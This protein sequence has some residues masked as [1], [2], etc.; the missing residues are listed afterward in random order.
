MFINDLKYFLEKIDHYRDE[1]L[2]VFIKPCWPRKISPNQL[3]YIRIAIGT[4]LIVLLFFFKIENKP[5]IISL[6]CV[7]AITDIFDGSVA[8]GLSEV[9][10]LGTMLDP[11]ADRILILPIAIYSLYGPHKW[12]LLFFLLAEALGAIISI[13][14]KSK[15]KDIKPNIFGKT[16][17][18]LLSIVFAGILIFWPE[19]PSIFFIDIIWISLFFLC[20]SILARVL[21]MNKKG[22]IKNKII[23]KQ[24][25]HYEN[26]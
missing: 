6:F 18:V 11:I 24:L 1:L 23:N 3:T 25:Q 22:F 13:F 15:D 17:M 16:K 7:G 10:E 20:L 5:L 21:E 9:S 19:P 14:H 4:V 26:L 8:R 12:L 2:F